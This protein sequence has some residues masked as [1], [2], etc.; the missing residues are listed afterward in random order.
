MAFRV[1]RYKVCMR[2]V[3]QGWKAED[4]ARRAKAGQTLGC[5]HEGQQI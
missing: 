1:S 2:G 5:G 4:I 3:W